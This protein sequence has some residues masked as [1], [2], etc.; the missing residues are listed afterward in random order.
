MYKYISNELPHFFENGMLRLTQPSQFNDPF[1]LLPC[2]V[3]VMGEST[4]K[5][6]LEN[7]EVWLKEDRKNEPWYK[8]LIP[9]PIKLAVIK[10]FLK[11]KN[12][13]ITKVME[14]FDATGVSVAN[15]QYRNIIDQ[16]DGILCLSETADN[17]LMWSHY[18]N[19]H[20]GYVIEFDTSHEFFNQKIPN[21]KTGGLVEYAGSP[22]KVTYTKHRKIIPFWQKSMSDVFLTKGSDW[23]YEKEHRMVLPLELASKVIDDNIY[24]FH[25][26]FEAVK[27]I[28]FGAKCEDSFMQ[29]CIEQ[30]QLWSSKHR[31][32][33]MFKMEL[34]D[35]SFGLVQNKI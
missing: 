35:Q 34:S 3:D 13:H 17:L 2:Y 29:D 15:T 24:L 25:I 33:S 28:I 23:E 6:I 26:P 19:C 4:K 8:K 7:I 22:L 31:E 21:P 16:S 32:F 12:K 27:S 10:A 18:G 9:L 11:S 30:I 1:E 5:Y 20:Q 14:Q